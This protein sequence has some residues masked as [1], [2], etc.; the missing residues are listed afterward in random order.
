MLSCFLPEHRFLEIFSLLYIQELLL[1]RFQ[2]P[3]SDTTQI[4]TLMLYAK[5]SENKHY[6]LY[7]NINNFLEKVFTRLML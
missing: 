5:I 6:V 4:L 2:P 1:S 3:R 7:M